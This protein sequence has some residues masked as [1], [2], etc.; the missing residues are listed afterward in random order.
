MFVVFLAFRC[1]HDSDSISRFQQHRVT[2]GMD[3]IRAM[4]AFQSFANQ[5]QKRSRSASDALKYACQNWVVHLSRAPTPWDD[6]LNHIF[7]AF[8]NR[9]LLSWLERQW[10]LKGLRSCLI[11]LSEGQKLAK[12]RPVHVQP[13]T[14]LP[15]VDPDPQQSTMQVPRP[16]STSKISTRETSTSIMMELAPHP[17]TTASH[18]GTSN[19]RTL[20]G[21]WTNSNSALELAAPTPSKRPKATGTAC[22][23]TKAGESSKSI[24]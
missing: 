2:P 10:C 24:D 21:A 15:T 7:Q 23:H 22:L 18:A 19:K 13:I 4:I 20:D 1:Q 11:I 3:I 16:A 9:H 12:P 5:A 8:W 17:Q 6:T 14:L